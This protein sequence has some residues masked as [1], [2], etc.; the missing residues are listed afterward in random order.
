MKTS[1][2]YRRKWKFEQRDRA[3]NVIIT[4]LTMEENTKKSIARELTN[5]LELQI[6]EDDIQY[7]LKLN[8]SKD[9]DTTRNRVK[10]A[11]K[12]EA[13]RNRVYTD[14]K[15]LKGKE[16]WITEDLTPMRSKLSYLS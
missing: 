12:E 1:Q 10:V 15:K 9:G 16:V 14:K 2:N 11:F 13:K 3:R 7:V 4:G 5:K 6:K 8:S